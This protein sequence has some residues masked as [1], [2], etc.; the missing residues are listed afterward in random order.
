MLFSSSIFVYGF[1]PVVFGGY[2]LL[3]RLRRAHL[4]FAW[5]VAASLVFYGYHRPSF[6]LV[7]VT[8]VLVNY[9]LSLAIQRTRHR[10][11]LLWI[12]LAFNLLLL[13]TFKYLGFIAESTNAVLG[14]NLPILDLALP[15][16]ISFFTFQQ[17]AYLV[18][19]Y[20]G[21]ARP[22]SL[23]HYTLFVCFFPQLIIGPIVHHTEMMPQFRGHRFGTPRF[24]DFVAGAGYFYIGFLKK[25]VIADSMA[26][27]VD[28]VFAA[29]TTGEPV[30]MSAAWLAVVGF[31]IQIY[32]DFSGY[33]DMA[34]GLA[35]L[36]GI[37]LPWNFDSPYKA[38][39]LRDF[40]RRWH[41]TLSRWLRDYLYIP[42]GGAAVS[43]PRTLFNVSIVFLLGGLWHGAA[44]TFA[45]WGLLQG[46]GVIAVYATRRLG[47]A[48]PFLVGV[49]LTFAYTMFGWIFFRAES[50]TAAWA[51][52]GGLGGG[53]ELGTIA[54]HDAVRIALPLI[55][56]FFAP[57]SHVVIPSVLRFTDRWPKTPVIATII[58]FW[59]I[60]MALQLES[61]KEFIY[62][63]F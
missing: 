7:L 33:S 60:M 51:M 14:A 58:S 18:D 49:A 9:G 3:A 39:N 12:G 24:A 55:L 1:L 20:H 63:D 44:W 62:F 17:I 54:F 32:F 36:F 34:M 21:I 6:L 19:C 30:T 50:F 4:L 16:A 53:N 35:R 5:L 40:W 46:L 25:V 8:S 57:N 23:L 56:I 41:M 61:S 42:L 52:I 59:V 2:L 48:I 47:L 26:P 37:D 27:Y 43:A 13:G 45:F 29:A 10:R 22:V 15:L 38:A 31:A 11:L 28:P